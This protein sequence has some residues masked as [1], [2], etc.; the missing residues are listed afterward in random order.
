MQKQQR[1][2]KEPDNE[3]VFPNLHG[4]CDKKENLEPENIMQQVKHISTPFSRK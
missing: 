1:L 3:F 4:T 2:Q